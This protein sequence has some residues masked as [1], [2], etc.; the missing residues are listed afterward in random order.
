VPEAIV[1]KSTG[2]WYSLLDSDNKEWQARLKG[3]FKLEGGG[4]TNPIAV[5]DRVKFSPEPGN[6]NA[7]IEEI[8]PRKNYIIR[9]ASNLSR[10]EHIIAANLDHVI[11]IATLAQPRTSLGFIDRILVTAEAYHIPPVI[12]FNKKDICSDE[13]KGYVDDVI[14]MYHNVGYQAL[15]I[16]ALEKESIDKVAELIKDKTSLFTGH[17]GVGKSTLIN[18]LVPELKLKTGEISGF[19]NKGKHTTTF[20]EM[21]IVSPGTYIVDTP[22]IKEFGVVNIERGEISHYFPEMREL[23]SECKFNNCMH[24]NEPGCAIRE[25]VEN[26][27]IALPRYQSYLSLINAEDT[28]R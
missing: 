19:S 24:E 28:H 11:I 27:E 26:G 14:F 1:K 6:D 7:I 21:H 17:S 22:G 12:L 8:L 4:N 15:S 10:Q 5:G 16:S 3:K 23:L 2:S 13:D 18:A 25:A 20:A 9:K